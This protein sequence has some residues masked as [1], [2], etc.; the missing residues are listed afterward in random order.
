MNR[1]TSGTAANKPAGRRPPWRV[2]AVLALVLGAL[3]VPFVARTPSNHPSAQV[4]TAGPAPELAQIV[5]IHNRLEDD[6]SVDDVRRIAGRAAAHG[7][8]AVLFSSAFDDIADQP[9]VFFERLA[10]VRA[11]F[12]SLGLAVI[13]RV[14]SAGYAY[15]AL[16]HDRDYAAALPV[17]NALFVVDGASARHTGDSPPAVV[18]G[19]FES[20]RGNRARGFA[21]QDGPGRVSFVDDT[22]ARE[23]RASLRFEG[24]HGSR[25][26][27]GRVMQR[28]KVEPFRC[29]RVSFWAKSA[30]LDN[31][32]GV[33]GLVR[34]PDDRTL[35]FRAAKLERTDGWKQVTMGFNSLDA[36]E[37][38]VYAG[39]WRGGGGRLWIDD[40]RI[41]ETGMVNVLRR[42]GTPV[43]VR[44]EANGMVYEEGRDYRRIA[45]PNLNFLV[46]H[47]GPAIELTP[48]SRIADGERLRVDF[49]QALS[50]DGQIGACLSEGR[51]YELWRDAIG[52]VHTSLAPAWYHIGFD[53]V[54][55]GGWCEACRRRGVSGGE[56]LAG[57]VT[58]VAAMVRDVAPD[59]GVI[60]WS[61]MLDPNHNGQQSDYLF[62]GSFAG[63]WEDIPRSV[64]VAC[65]HR[66]TR[67]ASLEHFDRL[68]HRTIAAA[69]YDAATEREMEADAKEWIDALARVDGGAG[70]MYTTWRGRYELLE[71][72]GDY[73]ARRGARQ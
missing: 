33:R 22:V 31:S 50:L 58:R 26:G 6:A 44:G 61:D 16:K 38:L 42:A 17:N 67:R 56:M 51:I 37:V 71:A 18:N 34:T 72:F 29:Y 70:I 55:H 11:A 54:R 52:R 62:R 21:I 7:Y 15:P 40:L 49:Y 4:A 23:G 69:Y 13:A 60:V 68:G 48:Q 59:A 20:A 1:E 65:W 25:A 53:E 46:D 3:S 30:D 41:E 43:T 5:R 10:R 32:A 73:V 24:M 39:I 28:V 66:D 64:V 8:T 57:S 63:S 12:D 14:T 19:D 2:V 35:M 9:P 47:E 27:M 45:D 36:D